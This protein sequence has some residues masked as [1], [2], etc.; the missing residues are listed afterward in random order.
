M[1]DFLLKAGKL[2]VAEPFMMDNTFKRAVILLCEHD[3]VLGS[4]GFLLN[5]SIKIKMKDLMSDFPEF[6]GTIY[7]GGPVAPDTLHFVHTKGD[8][9]EDSIEICKG[10]YWGGKFEQLKFLIESKLILPK[11]IKF[12]LGYSGW[13]EGQ[14]DEEMKGK[15]WILADADFNYVFT[16]PHKKLWSKVLSNLGNSF[17]VIGDMTDSVSLN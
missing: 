1:E 4:I 6:E 7:H 3:D 12:F 2:L 15:S 14:L 9:L 5:R 13:S 16:L 10:V 8:I 11:D 17:S